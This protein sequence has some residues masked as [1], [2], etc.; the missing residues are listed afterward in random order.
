MDQRF[1]YEI[2]YALAARDGREQAL[3]GKCAPAA[4]EAFA[5][6]VPAGTMPEIW[7]EAPLLGEPRFD[8]HVLTSREALNPESPFP[9][10]ET[11]GFPEAFRWFAGQE[12]TVRQLALSWDLYPDQVPSPAVQLLVSR[13]KPD[14]VPGFLSAAGRED[15]AERYRIF[16]GRIPENWFACYFG[17]FPGRP[18]SNLRVECIPKHPLQAAYAEDPELLRKHLEQAGFS[19]FGETM[20]SRCQTLARTPFQLEFQFDIGED[21][22]PGPVLGAS[23]R[24][25]CPPGESGWY[26]FDTEEADRLM[27]QISGWGLADDRWKHLK[28]TIF[29]TRV[30]RGEEKSRIFCFTA[31]IKLRWR[32]GEPLDAKAYLMA[33][34]EKAGEEP[35]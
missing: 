9:P 25:A 2:L 12:Q 23:L 26:S 27:E 29:A 17:V 8:L 11:G 34:M 4:R 13:A 18:G 21:G 1:L 33:G 10:E 7:F 19:A 15:A 28:K 31:F 30:A 14:T 16:T 20:L 32:G 5:R 22:R 6:S 24:F 35:A 3:F